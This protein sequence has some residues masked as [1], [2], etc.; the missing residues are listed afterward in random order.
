[1]AR[2]TIDNVRGLGDFV[3]TYQWNLKFLTFPR[4]I[5]A[6]GAAS[7]SA[8]MNIRC[9]STD[10][11]KATSDKLSTSIRGHKVHQAGILQYSDNIPL[12]LAETVNNEVQKLLTGWREACWKVRTGVHQTKADAECLIQIERLNRQDKPIWQYTLIG[13]WL[14]DSAVPN[15]QSETTSGFDMTLNI[16]Y[17]LFTEGAL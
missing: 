1:M 13:A 3:T 8:A 10:I 14:F 2:P 7:T 4:G 9:K 16:A 17:D 15:L 5:Q 12:I 6:P 11:P